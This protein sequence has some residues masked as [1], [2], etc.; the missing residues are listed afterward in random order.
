MRL[1]RRTFIAT[2]ALA[3]A[4]IGGYAYLNETP[5]NVTRMPGISVA[6]AAAADLSDLNT[7]PA[8]GEKS[9][10]NPEAPV[11]IIE[12][13]AATCSH[14]ANFHTGT[15]KEL[16]TEFIDTGKIHFILREFPF[17]DA[18]L[19][20]FMIARCA[21]EDKYFPII[22]VLFE[23]QA[24][25]HSQDI[26]KELQGIAKLAGFTEKTFDACLKNEEIAKGILAIREKA[27]KSY[28]V[29]STPTFF[30]NGK[31]YEGG[32]DIEGF[33]KKIEEAAG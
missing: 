32:R 22:D 1:D 4:G 5:D 25:W 17:G 31:K 7:A 21:P 27:S 3:A 19:A 18:G 29:D 2:G 23:Q 6:N 9:L 8:M 14:C 11:T 24:K 10:G 16:K 28:G 26:F 20:A 33:R 13:A 12:Y 15:F 30:I